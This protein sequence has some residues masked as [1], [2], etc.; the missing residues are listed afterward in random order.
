MTEHPLSP[1]IFMLESIQ[2]GDERVRKLGMPSP[3]SQVEELLKNC[4][5]SGGV[6][7]NGPRT[8]RHQH[9]WPMLLLF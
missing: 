7:R 9:Y 4:I 2:G 1:T 6:Q 3:Y 8:W 5:A